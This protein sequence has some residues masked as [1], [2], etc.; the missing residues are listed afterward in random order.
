MQLLCSHVNRKL[1]VSVRVLMPVYVCHFLPPGKLM[2]Y[3]SIAFETD[4]DLSVEAP[5]DVCVHHD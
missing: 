5:F 4:D 2:S 1:R 3:F